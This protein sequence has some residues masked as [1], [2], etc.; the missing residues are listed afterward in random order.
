VAGA[1][2]L[3]LVL[4]MPWWPGGRQ[5]WSTRPDYRWRIPVID[6]FPGGDRWRH[7]RNVAIREWNG[8]G[9]KMWIDVQ[10]GEAYQTKAITLYRDQKGPFGW[11]LEDEQYGFAAFARND[12]GIPTIEHELGHALGF[13]HGGSGVMGAG[14]SRVTPVDCRGLRHYYGRRRAA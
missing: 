5:R 4:M 14:E 10:A 8:C 6:E 3:A 12:I 1:I 11:W 7:N 2:A 9:A 13:G